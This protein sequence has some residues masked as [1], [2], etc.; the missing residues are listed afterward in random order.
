MQRVAANRWSRESSHMSL[1]SHFNGPFPGPHG[2]CYYWW[3]I[4]VDG[5]SVFTAMAGGPD[6][7]EE[8]NVATPRAVKQQQSHRTWPLFLRRVGHMQWWG[9]RDVV[10]GR[11]RAPF[12]Q[13]YSRGRDGSSQGKAEWQ[14][15]RWDS[16][17]SLNCPQDTYL[18]PDKQAVERHGSIEWVAF[19]INLLSA[20]NSN[21]KTLLSSW[22]HQGH[23]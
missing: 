5:D 12:L 7:S 17:H 14:P 23:S 8:M 2:Q 3:D 4:S 15:T 9:R 22:N 10:T 21:L 1:E 6:C 13:L 11:T 20:R 18:L 16:P 19:Q